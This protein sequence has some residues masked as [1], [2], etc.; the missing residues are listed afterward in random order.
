MIELVRESF[1][2]TVL[3]K[4][5][6][7]RERF[8]RLASLVGLVPLARLVYPSVLDRL[9]VVCAAFVEDVG[10][11]GCAGCVGWCGG[12]GA[13]WMGPGW[14]GWWKRCGGGARM[15]WGCR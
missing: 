15:E 13:K 6:L 10:G 9:P 8:A 2:K 3:E 11:D 4:A 1:L 12:M 5:G 14:R 7:H